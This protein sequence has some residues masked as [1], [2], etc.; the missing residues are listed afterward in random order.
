M[1]VTAMLPHRA[2][3]DVDSDRNLPQISSRSTSFRIERIVG[4]LNFVVK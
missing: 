2:V 3:D 4:L 1:S